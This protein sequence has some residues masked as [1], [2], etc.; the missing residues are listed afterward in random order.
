M[1]TAA[2]GSGTVVATQNMTSGNSV[3][4]YAITRDTYGNVSNPSLTWSLA[5][6]TGGVVSGDLTPTSGTNSTFTGHL[7]GSAT[8]QGPSV[9]GSLTANSGN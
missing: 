3:T 6:I 7:V 8:I 9:T 5:A 4:V 1:E 2:N